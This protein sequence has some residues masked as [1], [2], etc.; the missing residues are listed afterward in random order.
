MHKFNS[1]M[2]FKKFFKDINNFFLIMLLSF[3]LI[4]WV[5]QAVNFLDF[6]TDDGHGLIVYIKYTLL[7]LPKIFSKLIPVIFFVSIYFIISKYEDNNEIK[8]FWFLGVS[9]VEIV[10]KMLK[11]S[12]LFTILLLILTIFIVPASQY[13]ARQFIQES[14][15]DFFPSLIHEKEFIDTVEGL[16]IFIEKKVNNRYQNIFLKDD[17]NINKKIIYAKNGKLINNENQRALILNNGKIIN[18]NNSNI[19]EFNFKTTTF[20]LSEYVTT[21][22]IDFKVQEKQK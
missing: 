7:N 2:I 19:T 16:T 10:N 6:V 15:I 1:K 21:S 17:K 3:G 13:K 5:I 12:L 18:I 11:H 8:I 9:R 20:D 14:N 22:I 4:V